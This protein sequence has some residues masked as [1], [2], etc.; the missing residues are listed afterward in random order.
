MHY[1]IRNNGKNV[2]SWRRASRYS[3][4]LLHRKKGPAVTPKQGRKEWFLEGH[5]YRFIKHDDFLETNTY[6]HSQDDWVKSS[7]LKNPAVIYKNGTKEWH[8]FGELHRNADEG[9]AIEYSNG[10]KEWYFYGR[11]HRE[12][13]PAVV[14]GKKQYWYIHGELIKCIF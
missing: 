8:C 1:L 10:D 7:F 5:E 12:N 4:F 2:E 14:Y 6:S 11:R 13:G 9:P 3:T